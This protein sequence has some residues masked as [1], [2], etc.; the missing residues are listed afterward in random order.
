M[1]EDS[2]AREALAAS[3]AVAYDAGDLGCGDG[4][5][6]EFRRRIAEVPAG[7]RLAVTVR[8]PSAKADLP[9]L[10]RLL[11]HLVL[12]EEPLGDGRLVITVER[13]HE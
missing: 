12:S 6:R 9:P 5:G 7:A 10:A 4:L 1:V 13:R 8:D 2:P 3:R 11:G